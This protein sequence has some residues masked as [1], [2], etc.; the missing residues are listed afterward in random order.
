MVS[1]P[2][3]SASDEAVPSNRRGID[4]WVLVRLMMCWRVSQRDSRHAA[5][6][7]EY[8]GQRI[9]CA[10]LGIISLEDILRFASIL[11]SVIGIG[12]W[13]KLMTDQHRR[14][15]HSTAISTASHKCSQR[16]I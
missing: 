13:A 10:G 11:R 1:F 16:Q 12:P 6:E 2:P 3:A 4:F 8:L 9:Y 14:L 5:I 15:A 7:R